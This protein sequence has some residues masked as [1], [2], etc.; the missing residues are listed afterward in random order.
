MI[1][2]DRRTSGG[3]RGFTIWLCGSRDGTAP[4]IR[5]EPLEVYRKLEQEFHAA[6]LHRPMRIE[7]YEAG[8]EL[9]YD[10]IA[11][12]GRNR[13]KVRLRIEKFVGGGFAGQVYRVKVHNIQNDQGPIGDLEQGGVFA[14]KI[15][16]PPTAFSRFFRNV[17]YFI[18]FHLLFSVLGKKL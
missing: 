14:M 16:V 12:A 6:D 1:V 3:E 8:T 4:M 17:L 9:E 10:I 13:G 15:L 11:V 5:Y 7:R 2:D 18:G